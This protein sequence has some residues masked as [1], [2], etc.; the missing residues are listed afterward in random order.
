MKIAIHNSPDG[1][2]PRW[3]RYCDE[4]HIPYKRVNCYANDI[5]EQLKECNALMWHFSQGNP[6]DI[7][8]AKPLLYALQQSGKKVFPDFNTSWHFDD[9]LGQKYL[10]ESLGA[11]FAPTWIF[12]DEHEAISWAN[13]TTF[14][15]FFKLR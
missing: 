11:N 12:Y 8:L 9:K 10:L 14:P 5:I 6:H 3:I 4:Q 13:Q 1:F 15:T 7:L 2:H